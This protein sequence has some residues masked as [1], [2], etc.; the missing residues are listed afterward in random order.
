LSPTLPLNHDEWGTS[1]VPEDQAG[2][3]LSR[4]LFALENTTGS[5]LVLELQQQNSIFFDS[6][7]GKQ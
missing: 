6:A 1:F 7:M 2:A 5:Q 4:P 3:H